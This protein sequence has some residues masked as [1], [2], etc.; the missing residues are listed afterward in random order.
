[1]HKVPLT[2]EKKKKGTLYLSPLKFI[3]TVFVKP[4]L[5]FSFLYTLWIKIVS[6]TQS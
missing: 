2:K 3:F 6:A 4:H 5:G 1:M